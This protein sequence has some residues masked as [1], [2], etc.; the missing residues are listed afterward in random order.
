MNRIRNQKM[1]IN[2]NL[3]LALFLLFT[4]SCFYPVNAQNQDTRQDIPFIPLPDNSSQ[5]RLYRQM[6]RKNQLENYRY[7]QDKQNKITQN[8]TP[9]KDADNQ[10]EV[11]QFPY[12]QEDLNPIEVHQKKSEIAPAKVS[13]P[14]TRNVWDK[15]NVIV[16][17]NLAK[18]NDY[19]TNSH[20]DKNS[21]KKGRFTPKQG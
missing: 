16:A 15:K 4:I 1:K 9:S 20:T 10:K 14:K 18:A 17:E 6:V 2:S 11:K 21:K 7:N 13:I 8:T 3:L 19:A 12:I 5:Q